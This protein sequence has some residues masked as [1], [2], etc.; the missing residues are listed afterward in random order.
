MRCRLL[1]ISKDLVVLWLLIDC[2][3]YS[4]TVQEGPPRC[5]AW[6]L[7][8]THQSL[9]NAPMQNINYSDTFQQVDKKNTI[10]AKNIL[11]KQGSKKHSWSPKLSFWFL[12]WLSIMCTEYIILYCMIER[13]H[14]QDENRTDLLKELSMDAVIEWRTNIFFITGWW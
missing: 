3:L 14:Q 10:E 5:F 8:Y 9:V 12:I 11:G 4:T 13:Q 2:L 1:H 7:V 6:S